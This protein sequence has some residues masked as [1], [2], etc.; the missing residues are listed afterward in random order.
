VNNLQVKV[1]EEDGVVSVAVAGEL[2]LATAR[3]LESTIR[4]AEMARPLLLIIDLSQLRF[5]DSTGLRTIIAAHTRA[6]EDGRRVAIIP[7][8]EPVQKVFQLAL[9]EKRLNFI[10]DASEATGA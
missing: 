10:D 9:L 4:G 2:D 3:R 8:P 5:I 7:G 1:R 6:H